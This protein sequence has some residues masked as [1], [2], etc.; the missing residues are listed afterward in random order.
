M[1]GLQVEREKVEERERKTER[2]RERERR[3]EKT[4]TKG[5][6]EGSEREE[7]GIRERESKVG[8]EHPF[9]WTSLLL[10]TIQLLKSRTPFILETNGW[11]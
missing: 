4:K 11:N 9:L 2:E 10:G 8:A 7:K 6:G 3:R 5:R 1:L